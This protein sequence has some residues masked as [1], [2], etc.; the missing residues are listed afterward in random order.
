M[1]NEARLMSIEEFEA[2]TPNER[3]AVVKSSIV[4]DWAALPPEI[5]E[6]T[7]RRAGEFDREI[8][9]RLAP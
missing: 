9:Q 2:L 3:D 8:A 1:S 7:V 5:R 4:T 6:R